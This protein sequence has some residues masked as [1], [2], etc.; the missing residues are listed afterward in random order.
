MDRSIPAGAAVLVAV[1]LLLECLPCI[2]HLGG[3][4]QSLPNRLI[5]EKA[6][7]LPH[8]AVVDWK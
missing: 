5:I 3:S 7:K 8:L 6:I 2:P 4:K 1:H